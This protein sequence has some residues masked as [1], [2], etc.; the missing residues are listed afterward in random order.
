MK[1]SIP[2][3]SLLAS[4]MMTLSNKS[5]RTSFWKSLRPTKS[6]KLILKS[7]LMRFLKKSLKLKDN[8]NKIKTGLNHCL[9]LKRI[10]I[11]WWS[12][13]KIDKTK[14]QGSDRS[15][16]KFRNKDLKI[17]SRS[18]N[19]NLVLMKPELNEMKLINRLKLIALKLKRQILHSE[20][21]LSFY[22]ESNKKI[23]LD[24]KVFW[25]N[26]YKL[27]NQQSTFY[28]ILPLKE[29]FS[30]SFV[31][32]QQKLKEFWNSIKKLKEVMLQFLLLS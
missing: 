18:K 17:C 16:S 25:L 12:K 32:H 31:K 1:S 15:E 10:W 20:M 19:C 2:N 23:S 29:D 9:T 30:P 13:L 27:Q 28:L 4:N 21:F 7:K 14:L 3:F 6:L 8:L 11:M 5:M 26:I 24:S 22:K